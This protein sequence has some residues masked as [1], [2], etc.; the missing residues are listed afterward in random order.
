MIKKMFVLIITRAI[1]LPKYS[2]IVPVADLLNHENNQCVFV[3]EK[4]IENLLNEL[5][6]L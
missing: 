5:E 4:E 3:T 6:T 2:G 1:N